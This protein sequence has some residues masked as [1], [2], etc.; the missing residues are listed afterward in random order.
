MKNPKNLLL[1]S[2]F[3]LIIFFVIGTDANSMLV[4][5][6]YCLEN[7]TCNMSVD[8]SISQDSDPID[9]DKIDHSYILGFKEVKKCQKSLLLICSPIENF[10]FSVWQP[11]KIF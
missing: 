9:E 10:C 4:K 3:L 6:H 2:I 1:R 11:P 5:P 7:S 8:N